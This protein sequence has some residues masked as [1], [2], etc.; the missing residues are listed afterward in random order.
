LTLSPPRLSHALP[1]HRHVPTPFAKIHPRSHTPYLGIA[2][3]ALCALA[4]SLLFDLRS[5]IAISVFFLGLCYVA[6]AVSAL[7]LVQRNP[8]RRLHIPALR[9]MLV[10]AGLAGAY[11]SLQAPPPLLAFGV[12]A[13]LVGLAAYLL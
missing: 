12:L 5:L 4:A 8:A 9:P 2:F 10:L 6:T 1:T 3:Q 13:M 11:L 7:R